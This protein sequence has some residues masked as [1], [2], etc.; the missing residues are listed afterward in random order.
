M[1]L[2]AKNVTLASFLWTILITPFVFF[3]AG[4]YLKWRYSLVAIIGFGV[5]C[6]LG[7]PVDL[8]WFNQENLIVFCCITLFLWAIATLLSVFDQFRY[9][10]WEC[11]ATNSP[12]ANIV[13]AFVTALLKADFGAAYEICS[14]TFKSHSNL[15]QFQ[16]S[17]QAALDTLG[18]HPSVM[19]L[20]RPG[21][22][23]LP[24]LAGNLGLLNSVAASNVS[25]VALTL[26]QSDHDSV[27][28]TKT[29]S[30]LRIILQD[31]QRGPRVGGFS[32]VIVALNQHI[33]R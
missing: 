15:H 16:E 19:P 18:I 5:A 22:F 26:F 31:S 2:V 28:S 9:Q 8:S 20:N 11:C 4:C 7:A 29:V 6:L 10:G 24:I 14:D 12:S 17:A 1:S 13:A 21:T 25:A 32:P 27:Q 33:Y 3:L 30:G 23:E